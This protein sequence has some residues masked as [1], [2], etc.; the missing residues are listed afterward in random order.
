MEI[1]PA[2]LLE[3]VPE[4]VV[5]IV[6]VLV[7]EIVPVL[8]VDMV[9]LF[10]T[11]VRD[12]AKTSIAAPKVNFR[13]FIGSLLVRGTPEER[14]LPGM[15]PNS[16]LWSGLLLV[17]AGVHGPHITDARAARRLAKSAQSMSLSL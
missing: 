16:Q 15:V 7:V 3:V 17:R 14:H 1:I 9:P 8:V 10:A 13:F 4:I 11:A 2:R 12:I 5:E 6:P